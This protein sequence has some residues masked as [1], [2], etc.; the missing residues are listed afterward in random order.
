MGIL[1]DRD[2]GNHNH[3]GYSDPTA[4]AVFRSIDNDEQRLKKLLKVIFMSC[5]LSDFE[6]VGRISLIDK[7]TGTRYD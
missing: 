2:D 7:R 6:L 1:G 5:E 4:S 3:Y